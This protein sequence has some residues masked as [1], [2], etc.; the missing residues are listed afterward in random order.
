MMHYS[1]RWR[2]L[3]MF[4]LVVMVAIGA[5]ALFASEEASNRFRSYVDASHQTRDSQDVI[6]HIRATY[7]AQ[8]PRQLQKFVSQLSSAS[9]ERLI[10]VNHDQRVLADSEYKLTG[11]VLAFSQLYTL[12]ENDSDAIPVSPIQVLPGLHP[13]HIISLDEQKSIDIGPIP[14][15]MRPPTSEE[16]FINPLN[17][18]LGLAVLVAGLVAL[19]LT[20]ILSGTIIRP[21]QALM[22]AA[23]RMEQGD[24][25]QR[26]HIHSRDEIGALAHAFNTMADSLA[27]SEI[28]RRNLVSDVAH[29][30]RTPLTNIRGY[31]EALQDQVIDPTPELIAS[32]YEEALLLSRLVTDLQ[33][34][35]LAEAGQLHLAR[36]PLVLKE[37]I[38]KAT[39]GLLLQIV[40]KQLDLQMDVPADLPIVEADAERISQILRNLLYNAIKHT[41]S[42]GHIRVSARVLGAAVEVQV[43]DTGHG[44]APEHLPYLFKRFY[45]A[46][47]SRS[48][49]TG[50][51]G[52]GLAIVEQLVLAHGGRVGVESQVGVG[53]TFTF[54]IPLAHI[55]LPHA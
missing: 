23:R 42:G 32:L 2:L 41:A 26:V 53:T 9:G 50:G 13:L 8:G 51:T 28:L 18:S 48:R 43:Q 36:A 17:R 5:V 54:T 20:I 47:R 19:I 33:D 35:T 37:V 6:A 31:L 34:L 1:L 16:A 44:I 40:Q 21:V 27:R 52:L 45:R 12:A 38:E 14:L 11:Q 15:N 55:P 30:L 46:D 10:V 24:L 7:M 22:Q 25:K 29:E 49:A 3:F 39:T 4:M